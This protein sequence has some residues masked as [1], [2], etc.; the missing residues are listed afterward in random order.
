MNRVCSAFLLSLV[1]ISWCLAQPDTQ[2][3]PPQPPQPPGR[4]RQMGRPMPPRGMMGNIHGFVEQMKTELGLDAAQQS[5]IQ[6]MVDDYDKRMQESRQG[7]RPSPEESKQMSELREKLKKA[8]E[9]ND[10]NAVKEVSEEMQKVRKAQMDRMTPVRDQMTKA[11]DDLKN[12]LRSVLRDD[13]RTKFDKLWDDNMSTM[14]RSRKNPRLLKSMIERL[15]D[16]TSE[17]KQQITDLLKKQDEALRVQKDMTPTQRDEMSQK[18]YESMIA[19]LTPEQRE[20]V[21]ARLEGKP[22]SI[23]RGAETNP[24]PPTKP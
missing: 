5:T 7:L 19:V 4:D 17:Q 14:P 10:Q 11:Q 23:P 12:K 1:S 15:P 8:N 21:Q 24:H 13:Q 16:V 20:K 3:Q 9:A 2:N 6:G 22:G 18:T